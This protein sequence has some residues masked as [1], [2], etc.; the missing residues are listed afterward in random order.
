MMGD[1][2]ATL[3]ALCRSGA[4]A[5]LVT[6]VAAK[7]SVPRAPGTRMIVTA[8]A[9]HGTIGG[10]QLEYKAVEIARDLLAHRGRRA[11]HRFPLGASLGQCCGGL[12]QLL[13][14]PVGGAAAWIDALQ[15]HVSQSEDAVLIAPV[16][17]D[18]TLQR[19]VVG[20][21]TVSGTLGSAARD[22]EALA[23]ARAARLSGTPSGLATLDG[24][25]ECFVDVVRPPDFRIVLFGAGHVGRALVRA[26]SGVRC[27]I[28]WIDARD[29]AF[30]AVIPDIAKAVITDTPESE[31][32]RASAGDYFLVMTH[33]H[34]LDE[35]LAELILDRD[36]FAY[37]GL[38]GSTSKRRRFEKRMEAR[39]MPPSRFARMICPIGIAGV[40]G[41]E[42][43]VIA[44][45]VA[46]Q[47]LQLRDEK[48]AADAGCNPQ[49]ASGRAL[50]QHHAG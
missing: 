38:I 28:T 27:R 4:P 19:M 39:G 49:H 37:F 9:L 15:K 48:T 47:I 29:D 22:A 35:S 21:S 30:P 24:D 41:K 10:G 13:F 32:S 5:V 6:I 34:A 18:V 33:S 40:T 25:L 46:A 45:A 16:R 12:L 44:I 11:L 31:V 1:W 23:L 17:G 7:G 14:E 2:I 36:D 3:S 42:P 26:L 50:Q 43:D 20:P 8:D